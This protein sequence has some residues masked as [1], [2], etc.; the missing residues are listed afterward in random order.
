M[1]LKMRARTLKNQKQLKKK[2]MKTSSRMTHLTVIIALVPMVISPY[3]TTCIIRH[4]FSSLIPDL[5][6]LLHLP[7]LI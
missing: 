6:Y 2:Q 5:T 7:R 1:I 4:P 3:T